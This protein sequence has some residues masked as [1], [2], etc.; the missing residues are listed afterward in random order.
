MFP[1]ILNISNTYIFSLQTLNYYLLIEL[2]QA[3]K[4]LIV[5]DQHVMERSKH[6]TVCKDGLHNLSFK[7]RLLLNI[8]INIE[9]I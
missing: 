8:V 2:L 1:D 6:E 9:I 5:Y 3:T 7:W 4:R